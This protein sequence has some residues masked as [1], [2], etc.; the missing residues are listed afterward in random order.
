M[1]ELERRAESARRESQD[2][3]AVARAEGQRAAERVTAAEQG[4][5]AMKARQAENEVEL[6][7]PLA[8]T[9][10]VLQE[11]LAALE[12][13][14]SAL[15]L[16]WVTLESARKALEAEQRARSVADQEV[17]ALRGRVMGTKEPVPELVAPPSELD[18]KVKTLEQDLETTK[19]TLSQN[20]EELAKSHEEQ[21]ALEGD[22]DQICN[23]AQLVISEV[24]GSV[25]STST[26]AVQLAEVPDTIKDLV[27]SGLFYGA[28]GV[29]T[30]VTMHHPNLDFATIYSGYAKGLSMEDIQ[31]IGESLLSHA[32]SVSEQVSA[33]WVMDVRREDMA[34]SMSGEDASE[35]AD[36]TEPGSGG[37][38]ASAPIEPNVVLPGGSSLRLR[39]LR[40]Q[41]MPPG[42]FNS[43]HNIS[44]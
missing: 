7:A 5:E 11:A 14:Q 42:R 30:S 37:N 20:A 23:V 21:C 15:A 35:P 29:L 2:R 33:E 40:H 22:L 28:S 17:F 36:S 39:R 12:P 41:Q 27:R 25:P 18:G 32:R 31:S 1:A 16:E 6:R 13:E 44:S 19:A 10:T 4:L 34:R 26:P 43:L 9:E 24:F 38:V 8:S 3:A